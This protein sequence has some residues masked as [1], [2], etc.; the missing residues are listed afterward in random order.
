M[1]SQDT[2]LRSTRTWRGWP[3]VALIAGLGV[4]VSLVLIGL[5]NASE[6]A[7]ERVATAEIRKVADTLRLMVNGEVDGPEPLPVIDPTPKAT[8]FYGELERV[9]KTV[10]GERLAQHKAYLQDLK[11]I[12]MPR[13]LDAHRLARDTGLVESRMILEQAEHLVPKYQQQS[14][15]VLKDMPRLIGSLE[16]REPEKQKMLTSLNASLPR[17]SASLE[18]VWS[19]ETRILHEF[20]QMITLLDDNRSYWFADHDELMFERDSD[21]KRFH[22][23]M[24]AIGKM[25]SEQEQLGKQQLANIFSALP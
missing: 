20:G 7:Q 9:I 17:R 16:I 3:R 1:T 2:P 23:H 8:G 18:Q 10:A 14:M 15:Q 11:D 12:G 25:A 4:L 6:R 24:A 13:L 21:L 5:N 22:Q 19:L